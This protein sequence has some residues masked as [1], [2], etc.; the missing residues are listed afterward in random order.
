MREREE[1]VEVA[2]LRRRLDRR[3]VE[4]LGDRRDQRGCIDIRAR[5]RDRGRGWYFG[6]CWG[7]GGLFRLAPALT[8]GSGT[9]DD[10]QQPPHLR[11]CLLLGC[12]WLCTRVK[13]LLGVIL[14]ARA[15][16]KEIGSF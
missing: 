11:N 15:M 8:K 13:K 16:C 10:V 9:R 4:L 3:H 14:G 2:E 6:V 12:V 5:G 7:S 1:L